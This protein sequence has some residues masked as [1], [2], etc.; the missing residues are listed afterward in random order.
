[1]LYLQA[2]DFR[3]RKLHIPFYV[4]GMGW[5]LVSALV[6]IDEYYYRNLVIALLCLFVCSA[7]VLVYLDRQ[8]GWNWMPASINATL[9]LP[10]LV[11]IALYSA[12]ENSHVLV[13]PDVYFWVAALAA[14]YWMISRLESVAWPAWVNLASHTL[15]VFFV[16]LLLSAELVWLLDNRFALHDDGYSALIAA[17]PLLAMRIAQLRGFP[18]IARLGDGLQLSLLGTL[19]AFL[20]LCSLLLNL[21]NSGSAEPLPYIPLLNPVDLVQIAFFLL[22]IDSLKLLPASLAIQREHILILLAGLVFVWLTAVLIRS[23]HHFLEIR[24]D[25]SAMLR[26]TRV[27]TA[28]SILWTLIGMGAMLFA[29]RRSMRPLW[30]AGAAL[31]GVVLVKMLFIDLDASG[32]VER[33][34]SFLVVGALLVATGYFSPIPPKKSAAT[35]GNQQASRV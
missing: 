2:R 10:T 4:W 18:A 25:M 9:L 1:M 13:S 34:V 33:I 12:L 23:M 26:D 30:I 28:I 19:S 16:A 22:L 27:Q 17:A 3:L 35:S 29:S 21:T 5:W 31:I 24:F 15:L 11:L 20:C 6:Q 32:T 14:N 8:R 7:A